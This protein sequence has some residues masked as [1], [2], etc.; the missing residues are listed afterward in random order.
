M[1]M[2]LWNCT[3]GGCRT[4]LLR[5]AHAGP[6]L[7][8]CPYLQ[9]CPRQVA[10][11]AQLAEQELGLRRRQG[12]EGG[13]A[14]IERQARSVR[15][16]RRTCWLASVRASTQLQR[17]PLHRPAISWPGVIARPKPGHAQAPSPS[18]PAS[19]GYGCSP[20]PP[21]RL[22]LARAGANVP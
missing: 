7:R 3:A 18:R 10:V 6:A 2:G 19:E 17:P 11:R 15:R 5:H 4:A 21:A 8:G 20:G 9:L 22:V 13:A 1:K 12:G 16:R 14:A